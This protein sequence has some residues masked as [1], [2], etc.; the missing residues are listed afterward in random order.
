MN[1]GLIVLIIIIS[2]A[3]VVGGVFGFILLLRRTRKSAVKELQERYDQIHNSFSTDC[4]NMIK[5]IEDIANHNPK[6]S[7]ISTSVHQRFNVIL[8][9]ND[10]ICYIACESLKT[11]V[12]DKNYKDIKN[13]LHST[14]V[15]MDNFS[16]EAI[17]LNND[18]QSIL[19]EE[20]DIRGQIVVLREKFRNLKNAYSENQTALESLSKSFDTLFEHLTEGF[21]EFED[22]LNQ[23]DYSKLNQKIPE[24][25][26]LIDAAN[27]A[28]K[29]LPYLNT[30]AD[31]V[32]PERLEELKRT[33]QELE[34]QNYPLHH[35]MLKSNIEKMYQRLDECKSKLSN[36]STAGVGDVLNGITMQISTYFN[37]F[38]K[39]KQ[40]KKEFDSLQSSIFVSTYQAE[41]QYAN[42]K[43]S[44]PKYQK[45]YK[46]S[47]TYIEQIEVIKDMIDDMS[48]KKRMLD[49][50]INSSTKQPYSTLVTTMK[51]LKLRIDKVQNAF[52]NFHSYLKTLKEDADTSFSFIRSSFALLKEIERD[53][54][55]MN[56]PS[57]SE[58]FLPRIQMVYKGLVSLDRGLSN[59]P[60][61]ISQINSMRETLTENISSLQQEVNDAVKLMKSAE[62]LIV[63][64]NR[65]RTDYPSS[66]SKLEIAEKAFWEGD[67]S[68]S[69]SLGA[70]IYREQTDKYVK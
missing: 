57:Q 70:E 59:V 9:D 46:I 36:L 48:S 50:F 35:L 18:L 56:I 64:N 63:Y 1:P 38:E 30:L 69:A 51:E 16:R 25:D 43:S 29:D 26:K 66:R 34:S 62:D 37:D 49:G 44:L 58:L 22:I 7:Q 10:K 53:V 42:L 68:R 40:A 4:S 20:D 65:F 19:K 45:V 12:S 61:N 23:A 67:F 28:I 17:Q 55:N 47:P 5:R 15:S 11:M 6:F 41:K 13:V 8:N 33:Y 21:V 14:K 54:I 32:V 3:V 52:D 27:K 31:K 60:I 2:I 24:I 39:E